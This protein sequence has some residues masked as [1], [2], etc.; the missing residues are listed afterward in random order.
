MEEIQRVFEYHG[1]NTRWCGLLKS[2]APSMWKRRARARG[3]IP[4]VAQVFFCSDGHFHGVYMFLP[5]HTFWLRFLGASSC[6]RSLP[7]FLMSSIRFAAKSKGR[8][9]D[10]ASPAR[11]VLQRVTTREPDDSQL[12]T[13]IKAWKRPWN[14]SRIAAAN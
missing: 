7:E 10:W 5:F 1:A 12:E 3:F 2:V 9:W 8:L 13:A 6:C 4:V 14:L 11:L